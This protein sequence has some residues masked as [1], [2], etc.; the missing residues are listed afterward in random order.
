MADPFLVLSHLSKRFGEV[1]AVADLSLDI[2]RGEAVTLLGPS[3]CGKTT[4]LRMIAGLESP[5]AGAIRLNGKPLVSVE[6]GINLPPERR[7]MGMVFQSYAIWPHMTVA[8]N[9]AFPLRVRRAPASEI[10]ARVA[11]ALA[12]VGLAGYEDRPAPALSGGQQQRVALARALVYEPDILLL[13]EPL[14]NLD[15]KLREQMRV[16]IKLLRDRLNLTVIYV[17]HDQA[18]A[19]GLSDRIVMLNHGHIEQIGTP[20]EL[21]ERP[22]TPFVRDFLGKSIRLAGRIARIDGDGALVALDD[23]R[24][25]MLP[26]RRP[27]D[28]SLAAGSAVEVSVRPET[29]VIETGANGAS[30]G[31]LSG[32]VEAVLYQGE[33]SECEVRIGGQAALVFVP[34]SAEVVRDTEIW[35]RIPPEAAS[36]WRA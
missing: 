18:E 1:A 6:D 12:M 28:P 16:E 14:S 29:I 4:T 23:G 20:R 31:R 27:D 35:L 33:R 15:V 36:V 25:T 3:G 11:K 9:V 32:V 8:G 2:A 34:P 7:G 21:Y 10:R 17:T 19:L 5:D 24:G 22:R 26:C 30:S 13:D